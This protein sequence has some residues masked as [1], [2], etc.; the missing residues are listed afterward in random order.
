MRKTWIIVFMVAAVANVNAEVVCTRDYGGHLVI[1]ECWWLEDG[2]YYKLTDISTLEWQ[3]GLDGGWVF[4]IS[5]TETPYGF[6]IKPYLLFGSAYYDLPTV[7][8]AYPL[9]ELSQLVKGDNDFF[10][11][12]FNVSFGIVPPPLDVALVLDDSWGLTWADVELTGDYSVKIKDVILN[13]N[14]MAGDG[15]KLTLYN[16]TVF[17]VR[18]ITS[19]DFDPT[20]TLY[21][22]ITDVLDDSFTNEISA[23]ENYGNITTLQLNRNYGSYNKIS[24]IKFNL[25]QLSEATSINEAW[26]ELYISGESM[27]E[28][29]Y[30]N[31][32]LYLINQSNDWT[33]MGITYNNAPTEGRIDCGGYGS[34][35]IA[36]GDADIYYNASATACLS[37]ALIDLNYENITLE[38][39]PIYAESNQ[40][41]D[42]GYVRSMDWET[43]T[44]RPKLYVDYEVAGGDYITITYSAPADLAEIANGTRLQYN[45][46]VAN[47]TQT[48]DD[49]QLWA[50]VSGTWQPVNTSDASEGL[51]QLD[52]MFEDWGTYLWG[53]R[54][55]ST[56][57]VVNWTTTNR[58]IY[59][60][61]TTLAALPCR[62]V[63]DGDWVC[64]TGGE[65]IVTQD[66]VKTAGDL[67]VSNTT[68]LIFDG[69]NLTMAGD[70]AVYLNDSSQIWFR[71]GVIPQWS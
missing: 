64:D 25:S 10:K 57:A 46:T 8:L 14:G 59:V 65:C 45:F 3:G 35:R 13:Y 42:P 70:G 56:T 69:G 50:N 44:Q 6:K 28:G 66:L 11:W 51:N 39:L 68:T 24:Y 53:G 43:T 48:P 15:R 7:K 40:V 49:I 4:N 20:I 32:T 67:Y 41:N 30:V 61:T 60:T 63:L 12:D 22:N 1:G 17:I 23:D 26:L 71:D 29:E 16:K 27:E 34:I 54:V 18:N 58:T 55:N 62:A 47:E 21:D 33:E 19:W 31:A 2:E 36:D 38:L 9:L 37:L 5:E 52:Y